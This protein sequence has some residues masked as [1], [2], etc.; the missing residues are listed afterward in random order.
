M[1]QEHIA[2][3]GTVVHLGTLDLL[4]VTE[5]EFKHSALNK[6]IAMT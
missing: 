6:T 1:K 2:A 3:T 4:N 5:D